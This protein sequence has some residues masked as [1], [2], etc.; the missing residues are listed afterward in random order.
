MKW[1]PLL[2]CGITRTHSTL[3]IWCAS[4]ACAL[5]CALLHLNVHVMLTHIDVC[6]HLLRLA[7]EQWINRARQRALMG[8]ISLAL[9]YIFSEEAA[10][11]RDL[12]LRSVSAS[13]FLIV[14]K[15]HRGQNAM[16]FWTPISNW[17]VN[18]KSRP[19]PTRK[20]YFI[21]NFYLKITVIIKLVE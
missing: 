3:W 13:G 21:V 20:R 16:S 11:S 5:V 12:L 1:V 2:L 8:F 14:I 17:I 9:T 18:N 15:R 6:T 19:K 7:R 4:L 10:C